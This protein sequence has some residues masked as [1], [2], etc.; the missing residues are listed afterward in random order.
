M[1]MLGQHCLRLTSTTQTVIAMSSAESEFYAAVKSAAIGI[2]FVSLCE[3]LG[4]KFPKAVEVRIDA[5]ACL[6]IAARRGAGKIRHIATPTLW[7]QQAVYEQRVAVCNVKG[8]ANPADLGTKHVNE[9]PIESCWKTLGFKSESGRSARALK[10][11][12]A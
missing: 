9:A 2:G 12:T 1:A 8:T 3:D 11:S 10:A 4:I 5:S 7:L 6:G